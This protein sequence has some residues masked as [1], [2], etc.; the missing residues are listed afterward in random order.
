MCV[1]SN[2]LAVF[3]GLLQSEKCKKKIT[4]SIGTVSE[5]DQYGSLQISDVTSDEETLFVSRNAKTHT[6]RNGFTR[7]GRSKV[8]T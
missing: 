4:I 7:N 3:S 2:S 1:T 6:H 5:M 8:K